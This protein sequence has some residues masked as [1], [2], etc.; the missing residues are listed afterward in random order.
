MLP[1]FIDM[2]R[3]L[4]CPE[5]L[6]SLISSSE[7]LHSVYMYNFTMYKNPDVRDWNCRSFLKA[8]Q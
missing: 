3:L 1:A 4:A 7:A 2:Q 6:V 5:F 8:L